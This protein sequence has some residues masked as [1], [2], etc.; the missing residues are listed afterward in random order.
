VRGWL[1]PAKFAALTEQPHVVRVLTDTRVEPFRMAAPHHVDCTTTG[2]PIG[3]AARVAKELGVDWIWAAGYRGT[4]I[5]VGV[6]DGGI[7]AYGRPIKAGETAAIPTA[8]GVG[9]VTGG[10]PADWGTTAEGW[11]QHGNMMAF[12]IQAMAPEAELWDL[13]IWSPGVGGA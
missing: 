3:D 1:D 6:V 9:P 12:D 5:V 7:A 10:W 11:G 8:P 4:G 2:T 13:R